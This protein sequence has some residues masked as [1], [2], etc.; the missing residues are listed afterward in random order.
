MYNV[1]ENDVENDEVGKLMMSAGGYIAAAIALCLIGFFGFSLNLCV[2]IFMWRD[3]RI[4]TPLNILLFNLVISDFSVSIFGNPWTFVSSL[5]YGWVFG[6]IVCKA[7]GFFMSLLG[8]SSITT[9]TVLAFERYIIVSRPFRHRNLTRRGSIYL[10]LG[11]WIYS[12]LLTI[13]P[14]LGWGKYIN[15]AA[16]I[17]CSVNWEEQSPNAKSYIIFLFAFGLILPLSVIVF[18]Y[19]HI[20]N[21]IKRKTMKIGQVSKAEGRITY[22]VFFMI[23]AFLVAWT[24]YAITALLVQFGDRSLVSPAAGVIP[25]VLAKSSICYNPIIYVVLKSQLRQGVRNFLG[26]VNVNNTSACEVHD[27]GPS[28]FSETA[29]TALNRI[30]ISQCEGQPNAKI[31]CYENNL[32]EA[33]SQN[34]LEGIDVKIYQHDRLD[35]RNKATHF[36]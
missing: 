14:L 3:E 25:A 11:I 18:S 29:P 33:V 16:N 21:T 26:L 17:S 34:N 31:E 23:V 22:M 24:P 12:L 27:L 20:I 28:N 32:L 1:T 7:Y 10:I 9:L 5:S 8:I 4:W 36:L 30:F 6:K 2:I 13:P 15:E 35:A 19:A